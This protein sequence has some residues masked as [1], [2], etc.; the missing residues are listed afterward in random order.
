MKM[1]PAR[2]DDNREIVY[3]SPN[4]TNYNTPNA[5]SNKLM[6]GRRLQKRT[7]VNSPINH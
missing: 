5:Q 4:Y 7:Q 6:M 2:V 1:N 3:N